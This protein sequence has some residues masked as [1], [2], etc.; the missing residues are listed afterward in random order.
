MSC[1]KVATI[2]PRLSSVR[3]RMIRPE[4]PVRTI[5][6]RYHHENTRHQGNELPS[7]RRRVSK[8]FR[9]METR[10]RLAVRAASADSNGPDVSSRGGGGGGIAAEY[11]AIDPAAAPV[12]P[13]NFQQDHFSE[14]ALP[15]LC[16][17]RIPP[18]DLT[19][20]VGKGASALSH[21]R[22]V[23]AM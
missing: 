12:R 20:I 9:V 23:A 11:V 3:C 15:I 2:P 18:N 7:R 13:P 22:R 19:C 6:Q 21:R 10:L 4:I 14:P 17:A 16:F 1:P 5:L 8:K